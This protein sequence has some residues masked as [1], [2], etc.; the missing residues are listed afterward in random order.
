MLNTIRP[1]F[2]NLQNILIIGG[3]DM[4]PFRRVPD[5]VTIANE[6]A[7]NAF[8]IAQTPLDASL[9][10]RYFLTDNYYASFNPIPWA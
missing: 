8:T 6:S 1:A 10:E 3:D 4:I 7:Y 2:P 9:R 5:E